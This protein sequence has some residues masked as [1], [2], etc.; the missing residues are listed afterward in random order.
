MPAIRVKELIGNDVWNGYHKFCFERNPWDK[1]VSYY[2]WKTYGQKRRLPAFKAWVMEKTHR[3]PTDASLYFDG[4]S[5]LVDEVLE[6][7]G[8][9]QRFGE[10]CARLRIPFDGNMPTE[11]TNIT[12]QKV[13]YREYYDAESRE[14]VAVEFSR[15]IELM[16]YVFD[17]GG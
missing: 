16:G 7:D 1:V 2:N 6:Y 4:D 15:E 17:P 10:T 12:N 5:C 8:F 13:D 14:K 3:L 11:K 9:I